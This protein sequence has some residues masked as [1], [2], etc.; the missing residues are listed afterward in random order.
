MSRSSRSRF[1]QPLVDLPDTPAPCHALLMNAPRRSVSDEVHGLRAMGSF[2][3]GDFEEAIS[4]LEQ[5]SL[6]YLAGF[7]IRFGL[8]APSVALRVA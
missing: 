1:L 4:E 8:V 2:V 5:T 6:S 3:A 7:L